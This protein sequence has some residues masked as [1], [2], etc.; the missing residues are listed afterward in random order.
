MVRYARAYSLNSFHHDG[1]YSDRNQKLQRTKP[2]DYG[3]YRCCQIR[4]GATIALNAERRREYNF[5]CAWQVPLVNACANTAVSKYRVKQ[6][7]PADSPPR[8][9]RFELQTLV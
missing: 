5:A 7:W 2:N 9:G 1:K 6:R 4:R 8:R 3:Q